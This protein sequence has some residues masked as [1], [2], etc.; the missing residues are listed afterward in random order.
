[1][2]I[3]VT[4]ASGF[5]GSAL[6]PCLRADGHQVIRL[7]RGPSVPGETAV[8]WDP[9]AGVMETD[10]LKGI[11]AVIHLAGETVVGRWTP[12]KKKVIRD[13]R[14]HGTQL[15]ARTLAQLAHPPRT[16]ICAS[17]VGYYGHR[18]DDVLTETSAPGTGFLAEVGRAWEAAAQPAAQAGMRVVHVRIGMVLSVYGG[19]LAKMLPI[20]RLGL[21]GPIGH[22]RQYWSWVALDDVLGAIV[23]V[24][25]RAD[26]RGPVN[27]VAPQPSTN[28]A[29]T[30]TLGHVL[31]RPTVFP[32]PG[33]AAR[34]MLGEMAE[35]LLLAST[36]VEPARLL[37][38]GYQFR[39]PT[40]D[41]ALRHVVG[42]ER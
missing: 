3:L 23:H 40:L 19:A 42:R 18:G 7:T 31:G 21:G 12:A 24:L 17:A 10:G 20:F 37:S 41:G 39:Y 2:R 30:K 34:L 4:G 36:R 32:L 22:G 9:A 8:R 6:L 25:T 35:E 11:E 38:T 5:I 29:F 26:V 27:A 1:M 13:S 15:L 33:F 14:V 28:R 16:L